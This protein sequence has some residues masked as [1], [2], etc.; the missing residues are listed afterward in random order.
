MDLSGFSSDKAKVKYACAKQ[1]VEISKNCPEE[2]YPDL[3]FFNKLLESDNNIFKWTAIKVIGN[4]SKVDNKKKVDKILPAFIALLS[5]RKMIT[6]A[7]TI[8][9]LTEIAINKPEYIEMIINSLLKVENVNYYIKGDISPEC[10]NVTI[11]H[12]IKS[13]KK[14]GKT[15][16]YRKDVQA[17]L[18][19]QASSTRPK[20]KEMSEKLLIKIT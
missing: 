10:R 6:A 17:F 8:G 18:E 9:A 20:V 12:V 4:L 2:L 11:G 15:V 14:L 13:V 1:A 5:D 7:N 3:S 19:R 16:Y